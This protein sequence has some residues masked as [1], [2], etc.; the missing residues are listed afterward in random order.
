M[1]FY[2]SGGL[3]HAD[4]KEVELMSENS[5]EIMFAVNWIFLLS[6]LLGSWHTSGSDCNKIIDTCYLDGD[7][8]QYT[9]SP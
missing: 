4:S 3:V 5:R 9:L 8:A 7:R 2:L 6:K 1:F